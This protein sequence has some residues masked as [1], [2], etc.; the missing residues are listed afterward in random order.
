MSSLASLLISCTTVEIKVLTDCSQNDA[1]KKAG[2]ALQKETANCLKSIYSQIDI[3][4]VITFIIIAVLAFSAANVVSAASFNIY[5][6]GACAV[7][8]ADPVAGM[9]NPTLFIVNQ[10]FKSFTVGDVVYYNK[11]TLC[12]SVNTSSISYTDSGCTVCP[13]GPCSA[14]TTP[15]GTCIPSRGIPGVGSYKIGCV[16]SASPSAAIATLTFV[17]MIVGVLM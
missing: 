16:S 10:C 12:D 5:T 13:G 17:A 4:S 14:R 15:T 2:V 6:D 1:A 9:P 3:M 8:A 11:V 7:K